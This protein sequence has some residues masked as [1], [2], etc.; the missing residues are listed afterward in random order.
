MRCVKSI[1]ELYEESKEYDFVIT[2]DP[3]L[4]SAINL[5]IDMPKIGN[6]AY[7]PRDLA[8]KLTRT[9][10]GQALMDDFEIAE[11]IS[12]KTGYGFIEVYEDLKK[13]KEIWRYA[14]AKNYLYTEHEICVY[15]NL[16]KLPA[17]ESVMYR[18]KAEQA[19]FYA[20]KR[21]AVIGRQFFDFLERC[22]IPAGPEISIYGEGSFNPDK[23]YRLGNGRLIAE[24]IV[25][26]LD[27]ESAAHT[28]IVLNSEEMYSTMRSEL[29][30]KGIPCREIRS[31][32]ELPFVKNYLQFLTLAL[33]YPHLNAYESKEIFQ[34]CEAELPAD[35]CSLEEGCQGAREIK[36]LNLMS[37]I[38]EHTFAEACCITEDPP[39]AEY[40]KQ[41]L[42]Y[43]KYD[44]QK[45]C[46]DSLNRLDY[47][48]NNVS[49][50]PDCK[51]LAKMEN[52]VILKDC[53]NSSYVDREN[54]IFIGLDSAW[55]PKSYAEYAMV[56][57]NVWADAERFG[58]LIQQGLQ[59]YYLIHLTKQGRETKPCQMFSDFRR[60][61]GEE[62]ISEFS[63]L[64]TVVDG[65]E[66]TH[67]KERPFKITSTATLP[68]HSFSDYS[69]AQY[70]KCPRKYMFD[71]IFPL[72]DQEKILREFIEFC[73]CYPDI[74]KRTDPDLYES[75]IVSAENDC[76][77]SLR[78]EQVRVQIS[79]LQ[80]FIDNMGYKAPLNRNAEN[81]RFM[82]YHECLKSSSNVG[83]VLRSKNYNLIGRFDLLTTE[84]AVRINKGKRQ[85]LKELRNRLYA[86]AINPDC[87]PLALHY[88]LQEHGYD[89]PLQIV[90]LSD[91]DFELSE[92]VHEIRV[93]HKS[94]AELVYSAETSPLKYLL[95]AKKYAVIV[96]DLEPLIEILKESDLTVD[97]W[98]T[99]IEL[100][101]KVERAYALKTNIAED[102]LK[103]IKSLPQELIFLEDDFLLVPKDTLD[104]FM[105][106]FTEDSQKIAIEW[107]TDFPANV[108][109]CRNCHF[110]SICIREEGI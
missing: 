65:L 88:L 28:A 5:R 70:Q 80:S 66:K 37:T 99:K 60:M 89:V 102:A 27:A 51:H 13:I 71:K 11:E 39:E 8:R 7:T 48:I 100:V 84:C 74:V 17:V 1:D 61:S 93:S 57:E 69:Y 12:A 15:D 16:L 40:L 75:M 82:A 63:E 91:S 2:H 52:G 101:H 95:K 25:E 19:S 50:L 96:Q 98:W 104:A 90:Y 68:T 38:Q 53:Q 42:Q 10:C 77:R 106:K 83:I 4:S 107:Q 47:I 23:L 76:Q 43:V 35:G 31:P 62:R 36:L 32:K 103:A 97:E 55:E 86:D 9:L 54:V 59:K 105:L 73:F 94:W 109:G 46:K 92:N 3:D 108:D 20:N 30:R 33:K 18:F 58:I 6:L 34:A 64:C 45:I 21:I 67:Q 41:L 79:N 44:N 110:S 87:R 81:N 29:H 49:N 56:D 78:Y 24:S 26:L 85:T 72:P 22:F 14:D